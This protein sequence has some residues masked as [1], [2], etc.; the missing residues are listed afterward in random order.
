MNSISQLGA[1]YLEQFL[2]SYLFHPLLRNVCQSQ[3]NA[4]ISTI[5]FIA[6]ER[7]FSKPLS[8]NGLF[9]VCSLQRERACR[10]VV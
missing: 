7:D 10:T 5:V 1:N 9:R 2:C 6:T 4:V 8:S 3:D